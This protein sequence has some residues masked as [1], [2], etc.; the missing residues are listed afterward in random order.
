MAEDTVFA[1]IDPSETVSLTVGWPSGARTKLRHVPVGHEVAEAFRAVL[2]DTLEDL[3]DREAETWTPEADLSPET[4][5]ITDVE[6]LGLEP[7]LAAEHGDISLMTALLAAETLPDLDHAKLPASN[8]SFYAITV[9]KTAG[10]RAVFLRRTNPRRGLKRGRIYSVFSDTL[11]RVQEPIFAFDEW[12]DLVVVGDSVA[13]L[14]QTVFAALFRGQGAL[15]AQVPTWTKD[16]GEA[17]PIA[18]DGL[19]RL[20]AKVLR[21]SRA[22]QRLEAIV[23]RGHLST[24]NATTLRDAMGSAGL[25]PDTL[26]DADGRFI[27]EDDDIPSVL[28]FL[29][30]DLFAGALTQTSFRADKKAAR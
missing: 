3:A 6:S 26:M 29:N 1:S 4:Y 13:V 14:S 10:E 18:Q 22:R 27:L 8:L 30:E 25:D 17:V 16:L 24:V 5:L 23:R 11:E 12:M 19:E 21:D 2:R 28:H 20:E 15:N 7:K 9:G